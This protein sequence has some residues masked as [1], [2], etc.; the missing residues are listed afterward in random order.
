MKT[1]RFWMPVAVVTL[2]ALVMSGCG[3]K[4][5]EALPIDEAVDICEECKMQ[6]KDGVYAT[7]LTLADGKNYKFDDIGC[8][9]KWE[10]EH[11]Q[12]KLGMDF[13]RDYNDK[14]WIEHDKATYV[15]D[16][17]IRTP[18]AYGV[19]SFTDKKA[20]E[21]FVAKEGVGKVMS[22]EELAHHDWK[23][24]KDMMMGHEG[25]GS[26]DMKDMKGMDGTSERKQGHSDHP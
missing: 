17:S 24:N 19:I 13:V 3:A 22:A 21:E 6:V 23:Q 18:M 5:Y 25:S 12:E 10:K 11:A 16:P 9:E 1:K 8:M 20:A 26:G 7:Q 4:K 15:Y 2:G 14:T